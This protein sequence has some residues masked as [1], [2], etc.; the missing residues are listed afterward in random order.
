MTSTN[1]NKG[2]IKTASYNIIEDCNYSSKKYF[3]EADT[4]AAKHGNLSN[5]SIFLSGLTGVIG[6]TGAG[7]LH[8]KG[9]LNISN[10]KYRVL[11]LGICS[12]GGF[13]VSGLNVLLKSQDYLTKSIVARNI[14][15]EYL[16]LRKRVEVF[17]RLELPSIEIGNAIESL[18]AFNETIIGIDK[19]NPPLFDNTS[20]TK[21]QAGIKSG[22][23][24]YKSGQ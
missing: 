13:V 7:N 3:N 6:I 5:Y 10:T 20:F 23:A 16:A 2:D 18:K 8:E 21:A 19:R 4:L 1:V 24:N 9:V 14:A 22:E 12:L 17:Q 11:T 15:G